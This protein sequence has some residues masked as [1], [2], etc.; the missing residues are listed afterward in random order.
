MRNSNWRGFVLLAA[1]VVLCGRPAAAANLPDL[2]ISKYDINPFL[3]R[4]TFTSNSCEVVEG[5]ATPG[6]RRFIKFDTQTRNIGP[7]N[8]FLGSPI[9]NPL[10]RFNPCHG[11][12]HFE[13]FAIYR[14]LN[15]AGSLVATAYKAGF[16]LNDGT[17]VIPTPNNANSIYNDCNIQGIQSGWADTYGGAQTPCQ[18]IDITALPPGLYTLEME[19]DPAHLLAETDESNNITRLP[20]AIDALCAAAP[21]NDNY[22]AAQVITGTTAFILASNGC[23]TKEPGEPP[24]LGNVG[25]HSVWYRWT[26]PASLPTVFTTQGSTFDTVLAVYHGNAVNSLVLD[27]QDDDSGSNKTSRVTFNAV[28]GVEYHIAVDGWNGSAIGT[29]G[30]ATGGL[31]LTLNPALLTPPQFDAITRLPDIGTQLTL[32]GVTGLHYEIHSASTLDAWT[33]LQQ[34]TNSTGTIQFTDLT[35]T[36]GT[37][38]FYRAVLVP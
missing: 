6:T 26:A 38:R 8:L 11:H 15:S 3:A 13:Q 1:A 27:A 18:W 24:H 20:V 19:I 28:A 25:G 14:L 12:Y 22:S 7:G 33:S 36:N 30:G 5:C 4:Q 31:L 21:T 2:T 35:A 9:N 37:Q 29:I 16:C 32:T 23:A 34:V 17:R 10:F